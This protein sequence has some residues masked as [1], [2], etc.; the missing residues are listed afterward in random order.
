MN[1]L[2][3]PLQNPSITIGRNQRV[4][5]TASTLIKRG[6]PWVLVHSPFGGTAGA[7]DGRE[8]ALLALGSGK[9]PGIMVLAKYPTNPADSTMIGNGMLKKYM[10]IQ[11]DPARE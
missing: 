6:H 8:E 2:F 5:K 10:P 3:Q 1:V 11:A 7:G 4:R 9:S